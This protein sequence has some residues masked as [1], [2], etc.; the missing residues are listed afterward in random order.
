MNAFVKKEIRLLLPA[1]GISCALGLPNLFF[2]FHSD[3][4]LQDWWWVLLAFVACAATTVMLALNSFGQEIGSG[5]F[6]NLLAQPVSRQ[7]I[8]D[9]KISLLAVSLLIVATVWCGCGLVGLKITGQPLG[10]MDMFTG[11]VPFGLVVFTGGLWTVLLLRQVAAAFWF[12]VLVPGAILVIAAGL[13]GGESDEFMA[14]M[15]VSVLGVY[16][17]AGFF[18]AR[19]LFFR[20]QDL[21]WSGGNIVMPEMRGLARFKSPAALRI[22]RPR[23]ALWRKELQLHQSQFVVAFVIIVL[24]LGVL[25]VRNFCDLSHSHDLKVILQIFWGLWLMMPLLVGCAAVAEE[26]KLGTHEGQLCLPVKRRTQF[27]I[28]LVVALALSLIFGVIMPL[29]LEGRGILPDLHLELSSG[30]SASE[31]GQLPGSQRVFWDCLEYANLFLSLLS[32]AGVVLLVAGVSFYVSS[33]VRNT[34]QSLA[35]AVL[36]IILAWLLLAAGLIPWAQKV[37]FLWSGP[38]VY[39]ICVPLMAATLAALAFGNF[40]QAR[41]GWKTGGLNLLALVCVLVFGAAA[42]V[43]IYHRA[44]EKLTPFEPAHG[45]ARLSRSAPAVL[46]EH[47]GGVSVLL[48]DGKYWRGDW[49]YYPDRRNPLELL[50]GNFKPGLE[51]GSYFAETNWQLVMPLPSREFAGIKTDGSLWLSEITIPVGGW[52]NGQWRTAVSKLRK[53]TR[54]GSETNWTSLARFADS[55]LL[56]KNDGTLWVMGPTN[57]PNYY[58]SRRSWPGLRTFL[59]RRLGSETNWADVVQSGYRL[60]LHKTD[61]TGWI[62]GDDWQTN[63]IHAFDLQSGFTVHS[64]P[65]L[66]RGRFLSTA[67][68]WGGLCVMVGISTNGTLHVWAEQF[69][70]WDKKHSY[71]SW[72]WRPADWQIGDGTNWLAVAGGG[73]QKLVTLKKD[74]SL[75][76]W[77]FHYNHL[78]EVP[79]ENQVTA[80]D[81]Q[82]TVPIRLGSHTDWIAVSGEWGDVVTLAA[83]GSLWFWSL[84]NAADYSN[85]SN[86]KNSL[87][88]LLEYSRKP[89]LLGNIFNRAN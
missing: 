18:F 46:D 87:R 79:W 44:W 85:N 36:G 26:R 14:G 68:I 33:L 34:M 88:P 48:P 81:I 12:T 75:W 50:L 58:S 86:Q 54:F 9:T 74:G 17:L 66:E 71:G 67:Q 65:G 57:F 70:S 41:P 32:L 59:P 45:A 39:F 31:F 83:D 3:G 89:Q 80:A 77:N 61:G 30:W 27:A 52:T 25:A 6:S 62:T 49:A 47:W 23:A 84:G 73:G 78:S 55:I 82:S 51:G 53:M 11:V 2:R 16:S 42:T 21:Q 19:W 72:L 1:L 4:S 5:T 35:P 8:W 15:L 28:K 60:V 10:L 40:Q 20:A 56:V 22:W 64:A 43:M 63:G 7:K 38:L 13:F 24:H 76:L 37:E 29:L 69:V